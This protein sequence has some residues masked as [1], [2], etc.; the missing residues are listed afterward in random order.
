MMS[1]VL[2][3]IPQQ[4]MNM[5]DCISMASEISIPAKEV[6]IIDYWVTEYPRND[7]SNPFPFV[8]GL[9]EQKDV[10]FANNQ[11]VVLNIANLMFLNAMPLT[12]FEQNVLN[13]TF[14]TAIKNKPLLSGRK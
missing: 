6:P 14:K 2:T 11:D 1:L 9:F 4:E 10:A 13:N 7:N 3:D 8:Y 12:A 5:F